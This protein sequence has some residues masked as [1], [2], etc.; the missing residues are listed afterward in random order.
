VSVE[1]IHCPS[2]HRRKDSD[3]LMRI[4]DEKDESLLLMGVSKKSEQQRHEEG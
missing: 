3:V 4:A 1:R 2:K